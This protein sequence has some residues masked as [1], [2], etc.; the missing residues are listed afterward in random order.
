MS[1]DIDIEIDMMQDKIEGRCPECRQIL[2][3][4]VIGCET[5]LRD[6]GFKAGYKGIAK[7]DAGAYYAP[8]IPLEK[9]ESPVK[10]AVRYGMTINN[11]HQKIIVTDV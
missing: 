1:K 10:F 9:T 3:K 11:P 6:A 2:P 5:M 7:A 8:Y 4:H